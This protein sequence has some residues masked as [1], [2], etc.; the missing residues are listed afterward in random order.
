LAVLLIKEELPTAVLAAALP[1]AWLVGADGLLRMKSGRL[2]QPLTK[3]AAPQI[4]PFTL[5]VPN[6]CGG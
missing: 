6:R 4:H 3:T 5:T 2:E 1:L